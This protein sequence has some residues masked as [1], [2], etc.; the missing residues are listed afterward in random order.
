[1]T[2]KKRQTTHCSG[3]SERLNDCVDTSGRFEHIWTDKSARHTD[4]ARE[5]N[6]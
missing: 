2:R 1:M 6:H 5:T 3:S 4:L